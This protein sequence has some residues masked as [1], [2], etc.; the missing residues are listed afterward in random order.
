LLRVLQ[1][2]A[3]VNRNVGGPAISVSRLATVLAQE[4][5]DSILATLDYPLQGPQAF[6]EN[7]HMVSES[8]G[9]LAQCLR[10]WSPALRR[11]LMM[12]VHDGVSVVHNHGLW[13]FPNLYAR[14]A[15]I[16]AGVPLV[17]SPRGMLEE[18]SLGRSR[19]RKA[20]A[21]YLYERTN[22]KSAALFHATSEAEAGS[23]RAMGLDK[24]IAVIS[25]GIDVPDLSVVPDRKVLETRFPDLVGKRWLLFLSRLH[26]KKG[27]T[28][29]LHVWGN[30]ASRFPEWQLVI[31]GTDLD[32][33][34][35][36]VKREADALGLGNCITFTGMLVDNDKTCAL[37]NADLFVLP[38]YSEN[39]GIVVA[40]ALAQG[41]PVITTKAAPWKELSTN[42]CGWWIDTGEAALAATL[43]EAMQFPA[44]ERRTMGRRGRDLMVQRYSW[45]RVASEMKAVYL[46]LCKLGPRPDCVRTD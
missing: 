11:R 29:L 13:M 43:L 5:V 41:V 45:G 1:V 34:V 37:A 39:F 9:F 44:E 46:W 22:L 10:G 17:I 24:P 20:M 7:V 2:V 26:P 8:A 14:Q 27:I 19:V 42:N 32:G 4:G 16:A 30:L 25:N 3:S 38:T 28:E 15:A 12:T 31:A 21:W 33:Y 40:E 35:E 23:I 18:W 6:V 36:I